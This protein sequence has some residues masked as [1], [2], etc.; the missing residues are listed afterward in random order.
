MLL[1]L[2]ICEYNLRSLVLASAAVNCQS[3]VTL[4]LL[5]LLSQAAI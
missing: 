4:T 5:R 1:Q 3:I 2:F